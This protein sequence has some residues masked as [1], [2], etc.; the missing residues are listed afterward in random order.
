M[1]IAMSV[2]GS[3]V[4]LAIGGTLYYLITRKMICSA[5]SSPPP[6]TTTMTTTTATLGIS[7]DSNSHPQSSHTLP[8]TS[9]DIIP[10]LE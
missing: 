7:Q 10:E 6:T 4:A 8:I 5:S 3:V 2:I 1:T 9:N